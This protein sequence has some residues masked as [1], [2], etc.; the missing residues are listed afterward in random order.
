MST[1]FPPPPPRPPVPELSKVNHVHLSAVAGTGMGALAGMLK[2]RGFHVTGS[3]NNVYPPMST[4]LANAGIPV[5]TGYKAENLVPR[6]DLIIVGNALSR[7]NPEVEAMLES[8]IPYVSYPEAL[9]RFFIAGKHSIV[10]AGT[11]GKT[12]TCSLAAWVLESAGEH[13]SFL[14]GGVPKNFGHGQR[15]DSGKHFVVEGDEYDTAFFDKESKFLHYQ[16]KTAIVTSVEFDHADIFRDLDHV[17]AAFRKFVALIPKDGLL[18]YCADDAGAVD[19]ATSCTS[20]KESYSLKNRADWTVGN[21]VWRDGR[22]SFDVLKRGAK[23]VSVDSPMLGEHNL[24]NALGVIAALSGAGIAPA[25]IATGV[26]A[27]EG[28]KRRQ[29]VRGERHGVTVLDDFAHH[30]TAVKV[31]LDALKAGYPGR[32]LWAIFEPRSA[33]SRRKVF[34]QQYAEAFGAADKIVIADVYLADKMQA[35]LRFDPKQLAEDIRGRGKDAVALPNADEI[36]KAILP[37]AKPGD[38]IAVLSNGGFDGIH[39]KLLAGL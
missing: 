11:H 12:T 6:P 32:R 33:T 38:V 16:P 3:D 13:P 23:V 27:F 22:A 37:Q 9:S 25:K 20:P 36:V 29:E 17:K 15:L 34:Q 35:D 39:D 28:V 21:L 14:I 1:T 7:G 10:I 18:V 26:H 31:T 19:I 30:P 5:M 8:G 2:G 24:A 4:Q